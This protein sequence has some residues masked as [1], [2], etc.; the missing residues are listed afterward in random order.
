MFWISFHSQHILLSQSLLPL[1]TQIL[2]RNRLLS[3]PLSIHRATVLMTNHHSCIPVPVSPPP[4]PPLPLRSVHTALIRTLFLPHLLAIF[5]S[6]QR[7]HAMHI[8]ASCMPGSWDGSIRPLTWYTCNVF[9]K[10]EQSLVLSSLCVV[11]HSVVLHRC[12]HR[13]SIPLLGMAA[14]IQIAPLHLRTYVRQHPVTHASLVPSQ[15]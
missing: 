3:A 6:M 9:P 8:K 7:S 12:L 15:V 5:A 14:N 10:R 11:C 13:V 2:Y 1:S 4:P